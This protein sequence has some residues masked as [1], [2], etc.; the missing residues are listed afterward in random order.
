M[1]HATH[2]IKRQ[3]YSPGEAIIRR[4][5]PVNHFFMIGSGQAEVMDGHPTQPI[6]PVG[7]QFFGEVNCWAH[8]PPWQP[9]A[10]DKPRSNSAFFRAKNSTPSCKIC[11]QPQRC[12]VTWP[13]HA[14]KKTW[15]DHV[16]AVR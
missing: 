9:C 1:P 2:Q 16:E 5:E 11:R 12:C 15:H 10:P 3:R 14:C 8:P 7:N 4:G 6:A 13:P